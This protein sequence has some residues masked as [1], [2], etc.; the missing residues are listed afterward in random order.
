[1]SKFNK[2]I[3]EDEEI[4]IKE[5]LKEHPEKVDEIIEMV[6]TILGESVKKRDLIYESYID[7]TLKTGDT[8]NVAFIIATNDAETVKLHSVAVLNNPKKDLPELGTHYGKEI[9]KATKA[10]KRTFLPMMIVLGSEVWV[11]NSEKN[12]IEDIQDNGIQDKTTGK[13][14]KGIDADEAVLLASMSY[15][16]VMDTKLFNIE[17]NKKGK[18]VKLTQDERASSSNTSQSEFDYGESPLLESFFGAIKDEIKKAKD[19][20]MEISI[21]MLDLK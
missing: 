5:I 17:R 11:A 18:I 4:K 9:V 14:R 7:T 21:D 6:G 20:G 16:K 1:M 3:S 2:N 10:K 15:N 19:E 12:D 8:E 13:P